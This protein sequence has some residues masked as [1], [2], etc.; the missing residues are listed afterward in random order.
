MLDF[1][2]Y[3]LLQQLKPMGTFSL[4]SDDVR[5]GHELARPQWGAAA[6]GRD[7]SP[8]LRW[9]GFPPGT[10]S[11]AVTCFDPDAPSASGWWHWLVANIP[12]T[13][14][15]LDTDAGAARGAK[16]P[17]GA[18]TLPNDDRERRYAGPTPP[19]GT[20]VHRYFFVVTALNVPSVAVPPDAAPAVLGMRLHFHGIA[21]GILIG[22]ASGD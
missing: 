6:G 3:A 20:G 10:V 22:T 17:A 14:T 13:V 16:L 15:S 11:F 9:S 7:A 5:H 18:L 19:R 21:R 1:D 12:A 4:T 8:Q 2:P